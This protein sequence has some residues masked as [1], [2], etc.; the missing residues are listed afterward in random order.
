MDPLG[1]RFDQC[2][3]EVRGLESQRDELVR[4]LLRVHAPLLQAVARL[5]RAVDEAHKRLLPVQLDHIAVY[6]DVQQ[7]KRK[8]FR[9]ARGCIQSQVALAAQQYEV[10]Q[11]SV[12]QE[13]LKAEIQCL[14]QELSELQEGHQ[15]KL[16]CL[17]DEVSKPP[18]RRAR[19]LS[20]VSHCR[21]SSLSLQRRLSGSMQSLEGWY[22]PRLMAL[23]RWKQAGEEA[24]RRSKELGQ[25]LRAGLGP[26]EQDIR[27]LK[28]QR[29]CLEERL[30]LMERERQ[31]STAQRKETINLLEE[32]LRDL[33]V[34]FEIQRRSTTNVQSVQ[35][36]LL[37]ELA[38]LR[39]CNQ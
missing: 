23:L 35:D 8:L 27:G 28:L 26:L 7:V 36:R 20:D 33:K 30:A 14:T 29:A 19:A 10:A 2:I 9:A 15:K 5:R 22:E 31:E 1:A 37:R 32:T 18:C 3:Q 16:T 6:E 4:E 21:R 13:E 24:L 12:T 39:G 38:G 25:D 34:E 17:Q 11:S